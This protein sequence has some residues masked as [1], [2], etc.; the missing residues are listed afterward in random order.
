MRNKAADGDNTE[1][2]GARPRVGVKVEGERIRGGGGDQDAGENSENG[3]NKGGVRHL[4]TRM[5]RSPGSQTDAPGF[6]RV[7]K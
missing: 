3:L 2:K 5:L 7:S 6:T 4:W 1:H